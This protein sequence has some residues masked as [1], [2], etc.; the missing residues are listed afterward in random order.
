MA[1]FME[2]GNPVFNEKR[3][4]KESSA[5]SISGPITRNDT[6]TTDGAVNK[7]IFLFFLMM[8]TT[9]ISYIMPSTFLLWV[10]AIGG[11]VAVIVSVFKPQWSGTIAPGYALFEGLFLGTISFFYANAFYPGIIFQ[12]IGLTM[13]TLITML[14]VYKSG[15]IKVTDKFRTGVVM[16][17]GAIF[18]VYMLSWIGSMFGF[19]IPYLHEGG[20]LGIGISVVIIGVAALN[21]LLD[22]DLF[23]KGEQMQAPKYMEWFAAMSLLVTLVWLYVEFLRLLSKLNRD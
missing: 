10:G 20:V 16:A 7:S 2:P 23:E 13:G 6:M 4:R 1:N 18:V 3:L 11:L 9:C 19:T 5:R 15:L 21:L 17:T 12:A 14:L 8:I 22:F